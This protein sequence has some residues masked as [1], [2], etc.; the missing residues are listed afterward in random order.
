MTLDILAEH[1]T[2]CGYSTQEREFKEL[3]GRI[4]LY[5]PVENPGCLI[6]LVQEYESQPI[7][8]PAADDRIEQLREQ[9]KERNK[10]NP[11]T[12]YSHP[13]N[14]FSYSRWKDNQDLSSF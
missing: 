8:L 7:R 1:N 2:I 9:M 6:K 12:N 4:A 5:N 10:D 14:Q 13:L 3:H 11:N